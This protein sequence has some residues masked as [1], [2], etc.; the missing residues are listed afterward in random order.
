MKKMIIGIIIG[1]VSTLIIV[2]TIMYGIWEGGFSFLAP[3]YGTIDRYLMDNIDIFSQ[4]SNDLINLDYDTVVIRKD[5]PY[6]EDKYNMVVSKDMVFED[7]SSAINRKTIP[8]PDDLLD[9]IEHLY[10]SG[11]SVISCGDS[12]HIE[13]CMWSNRSESRGIK[14]SKTGEKPDGDQLIEV[15]QL[16]EENWYFYVYNYE[17][18]KARNPELFQ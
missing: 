12:D 11:V 10:N 5:F 14:Y 9:Q 16:S 18:T 7:G 3:S 17:K 13:F 15:K 2:F 1:V 8:I 6:E 4:I